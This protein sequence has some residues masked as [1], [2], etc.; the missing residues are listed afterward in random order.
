VWWVKKCLWEKGTISNPWT[1]C[2]SLYNDWERENK[3]YYIDPDW[4]WV[5]NAP[6][7]VYC[8]M[9]YDGWG[10]I[11]VMSSLRRYTTKPNVDFDSSFAS[12]H[13]KYVWW[14]NF[15]LSKYI[16]AWDIWIG[17]LRMEYEWKEASIFNLPE[18]ANTLN[19]L[20]YRPWTSYT[21]RIPPVSNSTKYPSQ[22]KVSFLP[23]RPQT[24]ICTDWFAVFWKDDRMLP[25]NTSGYDIPQLFHSCNRCST[26]PS[27]TVSLWYRRRDWI[28]RNFFINSH[29]DF[30]IFW[31][32]VYPANMTD[33]DIFKLWIK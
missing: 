13:W 22:T 20:F 21:W 15:Y 28:R 6:F 4:E 19:E 5:W 32:N 24:K 3:N 14:N 17:K 12:L 2:L 30:S 26:V 1:S 11:L 23:W 10:W 8:D 18:E 31:W 7:E 9:E 25:W 29:Y 33:T 16:R 27:A